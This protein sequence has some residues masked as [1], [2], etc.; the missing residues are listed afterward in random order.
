MK[1]DIIGWGDENYIE[2][3]S[4]KAV[5]CGFG[6]SWRYLGHRTD[7]YALL[8]DYHIG[9]MCSRSEGFGRV[10]AEYMHAGLGVIASDTGANRELIQDGVAGLIYKWGDTEELARCI[11]RFYRDRVLLEACGKAGRNYAVE[12]FTIE[13]CAQAVYQTYVELLGLE[14][15]VVGKR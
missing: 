3:I 11:E 4:K 8:Q 13:V 2:Q 12:N 7:I 14:T 5:S 9:F 10:T 6:D 15:N 1:L